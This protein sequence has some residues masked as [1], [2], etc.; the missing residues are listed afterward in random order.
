M[1]V[2]F[3]LLDSNRV[4]Q[5]LQKIHCA[6]ALASSA[7]QAC[8]HTHTHTQPH[9]SA[10]SS[11]SLCL[12]FL[13]V[14]ICIKQGLTLKFAPTDS[15]LDAMCVCV[16]VC[17]C[18]E[19]R[20]AAHIK[21]EISDLNGRMLDKVCCGEPLGLAWLEASLGVAVGQ[22]PPID[23]LQVT[24]ALG[25]VGFWVS[26]ELRTALEDSV[27][28]D[29]HPLCVE[30]IHRKAP[31]ACPSRCSSSSSR[32]QCLHLLFSEVSKRGW[33][34]GVGDKETPKKNPK[35]SPKMCPHIPKGA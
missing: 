13:H 8:T 11:V 12:C 29:I 21:D 31:A 27:E 2:F 28:P 20:S 4:R 23:P 17:A 24:L 1:R 6:F 18:V 3:S 22:S 26:W 10:L 7:T 15:F 33:R 5:F 9:T 19:L 34:D 16:L 14:A 32:R 25:S 30:R 35:S